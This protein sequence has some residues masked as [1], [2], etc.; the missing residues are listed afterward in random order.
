[1][2]LE[3]GSPRRQLRGSMSKDQETFHA[4]ALGVVR[5]GRARSEVQ[6]SVAVL[7]LAMA[8]NPD[9]ELE[10]DEPRRYA[11]LTTSR[12]QS[13]PGRGSRYTHRFPHR[14][15][16]RWNGGAQSRR[17][18]AIATMRGVELAANLREGADIMARRRGLIRSALRTAGRTAVI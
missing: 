3:I 8:F 18:P 6:E 13:A 17:A 16:F 12:D 7:F 15:R 14:I 9:V 1:M 4:I 10:A 2:T 5:L 11:F